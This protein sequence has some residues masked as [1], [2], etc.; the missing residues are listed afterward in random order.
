[1][2]IGDA[3]DVRTNPGRG[4]A[5]ALLRAP[6]LAGEAVT[7]EELKALETCPISRQ[8]CAHLRSIRDA[9]ERSVY[10]FTTCNTG[11]HSSCPGARGLYVELYGGIS[12]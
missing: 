6:G 2:A 11:E 8:V 9:D 7:T 3:I 12:N 1:M 4:E 10:M 5:A